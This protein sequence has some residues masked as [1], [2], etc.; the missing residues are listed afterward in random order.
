MERC[1]E[2]RT[3]EEISPSC[4][5]PSRPGTVSGVW[6]FASQKNFDE[7]SVSV[8]ILPTTGRKL[9]CAPRRERPERAYRSF[10]VISIGF[11]N[12]ECEVCERKFQSSL[13]STRSSLGQSAPHMLLHHGQLLSYIRSERLSI[14]ECRVREISSSSAKFTKSLEFLR[15]SRREQTGQSFCLIYHQSE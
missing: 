2:V 3:D 4:S 10:T 12:V 11:Q 5:E 6:R 8:Y 9:A 15:P 13:Y 7:L 1:L 14:R